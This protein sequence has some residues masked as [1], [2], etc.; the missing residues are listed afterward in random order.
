MI[1]K[2]NFTGIRNIAAANFTRNKLP[3][4]SLSMTLK[5]DL[6]DNTLDEFKSAVRKSGNS[7]FIDWE[8]PDVLNI[9]NAYDDI[10]KTN[11]LYINGIFLKSTDKNL[12]LFS[13]IAKITG[14]IADMKDKDFIVNETY[15]EYCVKDTLIYGK[16]FPKDTDM[17]EFFDS[18]GAKFCA[19]NINARI[20]D[21][22]REY[23][24]I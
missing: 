14:R 11:K 17:K 15:K 22:M 19:E 18:D 3:S 8:Y 13:F 12:P 4:E 10:A 1:N 6:N 24:E 7:D 16:K 21:V 5:N 23:F 20:D 9:E 2:I